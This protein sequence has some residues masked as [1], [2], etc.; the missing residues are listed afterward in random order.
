MGEMLF[1][2][3]DRLVNNCSRYITITNIR[4]NYFIRQYGEIIFR[5]MAEYY[6][7]NL[8]IVTGNLES[9]KN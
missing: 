7:Y 4:I 8:R 1:L 6:S 9:Q 3:R 5:N 2:G